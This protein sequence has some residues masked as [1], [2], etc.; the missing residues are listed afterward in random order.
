[1]N[2]QNNNIIKKKKY[3]NLYEW[4]YIMENTKQTDELATDRDVAR[5]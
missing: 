1:M 4:S 2:P 3:N 5:F